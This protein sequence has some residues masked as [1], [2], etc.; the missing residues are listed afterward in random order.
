MEDSTTT[1]DGRAAIVTGAGRGI[2]RAIAEML[3]EE[4]CSVAVV[5]RTAEELIETASACEEFGVETLV[6]PADI[7]DPGELSGVFERCHHEFR[8]LDILVNNAGLADHGT[9]FAADPDLWDRVLDVNL[10]AG[11]R[12]SRFALPYLLNSS[13]AAIVFIASLA[14]RT[15][16]GNMPAYVASKHG[17]LGFA[18]SLFSDIRERGIKVTTICPGLV[19]TSLSEPFEA[20]RNKMLYPEDVADA[21]RYVLL[22]P[23]HVCPTEIV[24]HPQYSPEN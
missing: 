5:A 13:Q 19:E 17:I 2:G 14:A 15:P 11:M 8:R 22:S 20:D 6:L 4:G 18:G 23:S 3:A 9:P 12:A 7:T 10:H 21:V 16:Y 1:L 24:L